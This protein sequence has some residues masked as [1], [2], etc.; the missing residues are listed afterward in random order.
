MRRFLP[1][2][3]VLLLAGCPAISNLL[4]P[5][6]VSGTVKFAKTGNA[7]IGN[8][9]SAYRLISA[10]ANEVSLTS[11]TV[12]ALKADGT[13]AGA[14]GETD[15][16]GAFKLE[17]LPTGKTLI[18]KGTKL[19]GSFTITVT[20]LY[21]SGGTRNLDT[22]SSVVAEKLV[23]NLTVAKIEALTQDQI[24]KLE[25]AVNAAIGATNTLPDL[26]KSGDA[27]DKYELLAIGSVDI[28][29]AYDAI[30]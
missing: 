14:S 4:A 6:S 26:T 22:V 30:K 13:D 12:K 23:K 5:G 3:L 2:P 17:K 16:S 24:G 15:A 19:N 20:A 1:F 7:L 25:T 28:K 18:L 21:S 10:V 8:S 29:A 11:G 9:G 27:I